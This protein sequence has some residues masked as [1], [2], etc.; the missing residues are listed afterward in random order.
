MKVELH[1]PE[2]GDWTVAY[3]DGEVI[4]SGHDHLNYLSEKLLALAGVEVEV[5]EYEDEEFE[6]KF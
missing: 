2:S 4:Y 5:F 6:E 1:R 3:I